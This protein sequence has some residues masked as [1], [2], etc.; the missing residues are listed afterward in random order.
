MK[1]TGFWIALIGVILVCS[2]LPLLLLRGDGE[3]GQARILLHG[4]ELRTVDLADA[5]S[6]TFVVEG[7]EGQRNVVAVEP[8]RIR[9]TEAS[10]P[11]QVCVR[12][13]WIRDGA[14]PIV[15]LPHGL[16]IEITGV[17]DGPDGAA[18]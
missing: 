11:D 2:A 6:E 1:K 5:S 8:G 12:Q 10:C 13:G 14:T 17:E 9:V 3:G 15:C 18:G 16:V 7:E 4:E